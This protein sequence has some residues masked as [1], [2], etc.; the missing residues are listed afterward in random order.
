MIDPFFIHQKS[1]NIKDARLN[2]F[3]GEVDGDIVIADSYRKK[4][5]QVWKSTFRMKIFSAC[6]LFIFA[7]IASR[8]YYLQIVQGAQYYGAAEGNRIQSIPIVPA[9]GVI[10]DLNGNRLAYNVPDFALFVIP[11]DLPKTQTEEDEIFSVLSK[12]LGIEHFD[13]V[14]A[15]SGIPRTSNEQVEMIRGISQVQAVAIARNVESWPGILLEPVQRRT[16]EIHESLSHVLGYTGKISDKDY[17][18]FSK[19]DYLLSEHVGKIGLEKQYQ[20]DLRGSLGIQLVEVDSKNQPMRELERKEPTIGDNLYLNIDSNLQEFIYQALK[21]MTE[22]K[23]SPGASAIVLDPR[24][25]SVRALVS[26]PGFDNEAFSRGISS[27]AYKEL[28]EDSREPLFNRSIAGEYPSGSTIKLV[29][30]S[31]SLEQGI[32]GRYD[33]VFSS[34][35]IDVN[36]YWFPDW[37]YGGHGQTNIIHALAES[38]NTYF[39]TVGG[40][41]GNI[42]GL[43]LDRII[44]Y[45]RAFGL[46]QKTQIDL[47]SEA[48]GFLPSEQWKEETKGERWYL[49]DTYHLAIGQGDI[50][51]TPLQVANYTA[52]IANG[53]TLYAPM[54]VDKVG[55]DYE[56]GR[57][58]EPVV[59][60]K[61]F[62]DP[63]NINVIQQGL[64]AAVEYGTVRSLS[65]LPVEAAGKTG[66][67]QFSSE[68]LPH[69][70][71][72]GYAPYRDPEIVVTIL[73]EEGEGG[74]LSAT[75]I[76]KKIFEWWF[77]NSD[78]I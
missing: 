70:W 56:H 38:V 14:E 31:A 72:T 15:F 48:E 8:L 75:P 59:L 74:D 19:N 24:D 52:V 11:S 2:V 23:E 36:G 77:N 27:S 40:G 10:F 44:E 45:G 39:Y 54:I 57:K 30:G 3:S 41:Y 49:G 55:R 60:N 18:Y 68:K 76:A 4:T 35:G 26:F 6:S 20:D 73:V 21:E 61:D 71:F 32:M 64:R 43:G 66:T 17:D 22:E 78:K 37:K 47:P 46:A 13:L 5:K 51:V 16:Y 12:T 50:L 28:L 7:I 34:G 29:I 33:T 65:A 62:I 58:I 1:A 42:E 53:G 69:A 25:G 63:Y 67:A 9:R